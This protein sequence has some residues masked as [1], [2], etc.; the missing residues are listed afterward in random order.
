MVRL[1]QA[2]VE[3]YNELFR[4]CAIAPDKVDAVNASVRKIVNSKDRYEGLFR[5]VSVPW[6]FIG[7]THAMEASLDFNKH[8]HNGDPLTARTVR[9][10]PGR[11][12]AGQPPFTWEDSALDAIRIKKLHTWGDWSI[13]GMLYKLES[14]NGFG[15]RIHH[16]EVRSPYLWSFTNHYTRGKYVSDGTFSPSAVS[17]QCGAAAL[18][19]RVAEVLD[20]QV[21]IGGVVASTTARIGASSPLIH[22]SSKEIPHAAELQR[23]LNTLPDVHLKID[24]KPGRRTSDAFKRVTGHY[25][26]GDP[27]DGSA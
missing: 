5:E 25:L 21:S 4:T 16:P 9:V 1:T 11:P 15:Y 17:K 20:G 13:A 23:F 10:P 6:Y 8:L 24:G 3:E 19:R 7:V 26:V 18:L 2:L 22:F 27:E 12:A 14:F